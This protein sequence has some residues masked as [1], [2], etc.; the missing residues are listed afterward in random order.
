MGDVFFVCNIVPNLQKS[1]V[2]NKIEITN[3]IVDSAE[4]KLKWPILG[5]TEALPNLRYIPSY[6]AL[7]LIAS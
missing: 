4:P 2:Q 6:Y 7:L 1:S 3:L 5:L